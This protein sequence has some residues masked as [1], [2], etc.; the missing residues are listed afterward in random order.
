VAAAECRQRIVRG[1]PLAPQALVALPHT[2][3]KFRRRPYTPF[4]RFFAGG[5]CGPIR[6]RCHLHRLYMGRMSKNEQSFTL[7]NPNKN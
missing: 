2:P 7:L 3:R 6:C 4:D 1:Q 5:L